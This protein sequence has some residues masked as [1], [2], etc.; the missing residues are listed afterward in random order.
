[1]KKLEKIAIDSIIENFT[2]NKREMIQSAISAKHA[3]EVAQ[4]NFKKVASPV[5]NYAKEVGNLLLED[6]VSDEAIT[7]FESRMT[8]IVKIP[9]SLKK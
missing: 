1:M 2:N 7:Y 6:G 9:F 8:E 4:Q 3:V 5:V